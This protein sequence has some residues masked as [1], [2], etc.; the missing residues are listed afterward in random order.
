M[1]PKKDLPLKRRRRTQFQ[2]LEP[3]IRREI[4]SYLQP[5]YA[6]QYSLGVLYETKAE[7]SM[8]RRQAESLAH[9]PIYQKLLTH[10]KEETEAYKAKLKE[11]TKT[12]GI[13]ETY[14]YF[15]DDSKPF[16]DQGSG[17]GSGGQTGP[18][19]S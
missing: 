3:A 17:P 16:P 14:R 12:P 2:D 7:L 19:T 15:W 18:I 5:T 8:L 11:V 9:R 10:E 13:W 6:Q 1:P 4:I